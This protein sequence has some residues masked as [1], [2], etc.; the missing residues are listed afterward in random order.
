M[1]RERTKKYKIK[2]KSGRDEER[3]GESWKEGQKKM[4]KKEKNDNNS[5]EETASSS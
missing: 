4:E 2:G 5:E 1:D 3:R